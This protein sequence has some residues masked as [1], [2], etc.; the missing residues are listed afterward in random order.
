MADSILDVK[1]LLN[2]YSL[3]IQEGIDKEAQEI[4]KQAASELKNHRGTYKIRT[5]KYNKGWRVNTKKGREFVNCT[6]H[7]A[8]DWQLTHLLENG[9]TTRN[10][11]RT[12]AFVHIRPVEEKY[13]NQYQQDVEK[14]IKNGG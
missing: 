14:L 10:G 9:H 2:E 6:V 1:D 13:V 8:T 12:K 3:D 11:G 4:S 7:N 5:G